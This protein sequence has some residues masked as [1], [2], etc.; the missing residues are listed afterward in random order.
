MYKK[1]TLLAALLCSSTQY[2]SDAMP[3]FEIKPS[4]FFFSASPMN[5]IYDNGGFEIQASA[6]VPFFK[7]LDFYSS[8]GYRQVSGHALNSD[9]KTSLTVLPLDIGLK[10]VF[11]IDE[12]FCYFF[13]V[14]PRFFYFNQR[15]NSPYVDQMINGGGVGLFA[16][17]GFNVRLAD[18]FL[19][20]IFGEYSYE[21][22]TIDTT[23]PNVFSNGSVQMGG[24]AFGLSLG[25]AF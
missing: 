8:I 21:K 10:P 2:A 15:N 13:A 7:H 6:S 19:L 18:S 9:E 16:N 24:F 12:R 3:W 11:K 4:Y 1:I 23:I 14:G 22:Q 17:T 20:G 5:E 25:Y